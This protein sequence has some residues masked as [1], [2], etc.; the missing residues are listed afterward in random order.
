MAET[1]HLKGISLRDLGGHKRQ[2]NQDFQV[3]LYAV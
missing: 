3:A 1:A 2:L